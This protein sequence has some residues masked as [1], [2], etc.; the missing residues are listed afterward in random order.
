M[1]EPFEYAI[2]TRKKVA[3]SKVQEFKRT[4]TDF[5]LII[6]TTRSQY[7]VKNELKAKIE[8]Y[9]ADLQAFDEYLQLIVD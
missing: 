2:T 9:E 5:R 6:S 1:T 4:L 7:E 8:E 3:L